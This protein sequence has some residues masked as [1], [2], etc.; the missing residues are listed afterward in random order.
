MEK[1]LN[2]IINY[3]KNSSYYKKCEI[4]KEEIKYNNEISSLL[5]EIKICQKLYSNGKIEKDKI[6]ELNNKLN[7]IPLYMEYKYNLDKVNMMIDI[8][9]YD[10]NQY[11]NDVVNML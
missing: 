11:F 6:D 10:I 3:I 8:V 7:D 5:E 2:D 4:L 9:S 1:E